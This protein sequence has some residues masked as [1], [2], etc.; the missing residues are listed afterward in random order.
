MYQE[1]KKMVYKR[2]LFRKFLKNVRHKI[3]TMINDDCRIAVEL[4]ITR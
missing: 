3:S 1:E 4:Q 2:S